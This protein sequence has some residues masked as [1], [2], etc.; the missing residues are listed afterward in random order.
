MK[1]QRLKERKGHGL[2]LGNDRNMFMSLL[3][4]EAFSELLNVCAPSC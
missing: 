3:K 2:S 4:T 1:A